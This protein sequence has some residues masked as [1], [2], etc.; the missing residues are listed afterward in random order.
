MKKI[1]LL[2]LLFVLTACTQSGSFVTLEMPNGDSVNAKL[3]ITEQEHEKG[4]S[5]IKK[6]EGY[7]AMWFVLDQPR[8]VA[9][10]MKDM[11]FNL[12]IVYLD[13]DKR[14]VEVHEN[15]KPCSKE[16]CYKIKSVHENVKYVLEV[17]AGKAIQFN[18]DIN[19][20][21]K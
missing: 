8:S 14:I 16:F 12:D 7:E 17:P 1:I 18:L 15:K 10:W 21:I 6:M 4:L 5:G 20:Q 9:F 13:E 2:F 11:K 19:K 3:A